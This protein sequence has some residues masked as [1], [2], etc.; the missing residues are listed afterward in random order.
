LYSSDGARN[1]SWLIYIVG[2]DERP[3]AHEL[4]NSDVDEIDWPAHSEPHV[5]TR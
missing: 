2:I 3:I 1:S 4:L 5:P